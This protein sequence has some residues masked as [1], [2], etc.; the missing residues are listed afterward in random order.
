[1]EGRFNVYKNIL[2]FESTI[3]TRNQGHTI[4][5]FSCCAGEVVLISGGSALA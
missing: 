1:M 3:K 2:C 4:Y 5:H